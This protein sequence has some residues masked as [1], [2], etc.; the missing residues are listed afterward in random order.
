MAVTIVATPKAVDANSYATRAEF[1]TYH[2]GHVDGE[3]SEDLDDALVDRALVQATRE[4]DSYLAWDGWSTTTTQRLAFPRAGLVDPN[5][6]AA[7]NADTIP[8]RLRDACC[9]QARLIAERNRAVESSTSTDGIQALKAGPIE[10]EFAKTQPGQAVVGQ[11]IAPSAFQLVACW[12]RVKQAGQGG[13]IP[14]VRV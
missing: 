4:F 5:T 7:V 12:A 9:E 10:I 11:V 13:P 3:A 8:D 14:L 2:E 6:Q 1:R